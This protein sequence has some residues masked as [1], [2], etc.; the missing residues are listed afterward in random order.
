MEQ[1]PIEKEARTKKTTKDKAVREKN[2]AV[3]VAKPAAKAKVEINAKVAKK[4][5]AAKGR[6]VAKVEVRAVVSRVDEAA[7]PG[8]LPGELIHA[9]AVQTLG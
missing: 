6:R 3:A 9:E 1:W 5:A 8:R 7:S 4:I 2:L